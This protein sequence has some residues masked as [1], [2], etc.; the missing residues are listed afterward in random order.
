[1]DVVDAFAQAVSVPDEEVNLA[2]AALLIAQARFPDLDVELQLRLLDGLARGAQELLGEDRDSLRDCNILSQY[3]FDEVGLRGNADD[4]YDPQNSYLNQVLARRTGIPISLSLVYIEVGRRLDI[5]L[6]GVGMPGHFLV[7]HRDVADL[8]IDPFYAG[9]MLSA[10][11]CAR[12]LQEVTGGRL[13]WRSDHLEPVGQRAFLGRMLRN[14]QVIYLQR[15]EYRHALD[16]LDL[17][18][19]LLPVDAAEQRDLQALK[20]QVKGWIV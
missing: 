4:Y 17:L 11:E 20:Q 13:H 7:R 10:E 16:V 18:T 12:R 8:Y 5:P 9:I 2:R 15:R 6:V 1:M 14:L 3:L 19:V